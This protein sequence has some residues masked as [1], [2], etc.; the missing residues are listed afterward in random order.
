MEQ[1]GNNLLY[2]IDEKSDETGK[3]LSLACAIH[4]NDPPIC[5]SFWSK[6][7]KSKKSTEFPSLV[8]HTPFESNIYWVK[9]F[10]LIN[11]TV[12]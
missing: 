2:L 7:G 10:I 4:T 3:S 11:S 8:L 5:P 12:F 9:K 1:I 6:L